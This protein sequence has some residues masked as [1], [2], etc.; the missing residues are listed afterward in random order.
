MQLIY[1]DDVLAGADGEETYTL[2]TASKEILSHAS[3]S[4]KSS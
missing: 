1:M 2:Y 3:F 4:L